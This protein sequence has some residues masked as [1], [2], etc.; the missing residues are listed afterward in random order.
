LRDRLRDFERRDAQLVIVTTATRV[1]ERGSHLILS[2]P[3]AVVCATYGV[4]FQVLG[5]ANRPATFV[6]DRQGVIRFLYLAGT[7][8][9]HVFYSAEPQYDAHWSYDRPSADELFH[10][11][12]GLEKRGTE[13]EQKLAALRKAGVPELIRALQSEESYLRAEAASVLAE[14][15]TKADAAVPALIAALKD[16]VGSVRSEAARALGKIGPK[17]KPAV[18]VLI[19]LLKDQD[20]GVRSAAALALGNLGP[21]A[22]GAVLALLWLAAADP[23]G[24]VQDSA[25][26]AVGRIGPAAIP[27]LKAALKA[28]R[29]QVRL[30]AVRGL[31][32]MGPKAEAAV[33]ALTESLKDR[34]AHVRAGA[35][36]ALGGIG[37]QARP[38]IPA[39]M[40]ALKDRYGGARMQAI[41]ALG[42]IDPE[43]PGLAAAL[44][45]ALA[46]E[47]DRVRHAAAS[48]LG[49]VRPIAM[50][51]VPAL[52]KALKEGGYIGLA[53]A[54]SL[55]RIDPESKDI[56]VPVLI[57]L[58][59]CE[60]AEVRVGA[61][62]LLK[63][64]DPAAA[65]KAGV[66]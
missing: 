52:K 12:D 7:K 49:Q 50:E 59:K 48:T 66:R 62:A 38:A 1:P 15:G 40:E 30:G 14:M 11:I 46:D 31:M 44:I 41:S 54:V 65:A 42:R 16:T 39:L 36:Q 33:L 13:Q 45:A 22:K 56:V 23:F 27:E 5:G 60:E 28:D 4:A 35:A 24:G 20:E 55:S 37:T 61:A 8:L 18:A 25:S 58:L 3:A 57:A 29:D 21:E 64:I 26:E 53:A 19:A 34:K 6:M 17:A 32:N 51:A 47:E 63:S 43:T 10:V 9:G 2:D